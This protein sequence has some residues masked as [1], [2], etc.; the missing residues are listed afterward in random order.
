MIPAIVLAAG[1][2]TRMGGDL[3]KPLLPWGQG[4]VVEHI[5][6][7]LR[8]AGLHDVIVV[9]GYQ[10]LA[11]ESALAAYP[12]RFAFNSDYASGE[13]LSSL[14]IGLRAV[15]ADPAGALIALADQPQLRQTIVERVIAAFVDGGSQAIVVPSYELRRGHPIVLPRWIWQE[16]L[17][18]PPGETLRTAID[19]HASAMT[20]VVVDT[21]AVLAD[22]DTP[23]QYR[24]ALNEQLP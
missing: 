18:L 6:S 2:S 15:P 14:K 8:A 22:M 4:T 7:T 3:P 20:Y 16:V 24:S 13:M 9:T 11:I 23:E 1:L 12:V 5:I 10:R 19:R 17:N 21:P